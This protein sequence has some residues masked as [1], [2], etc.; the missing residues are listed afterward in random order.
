MRP[1]DG[2]GKNDPVT[3]SG[4]TAADMP[5]LGG[6][7]AVVT[8]ANSGLGLHTT[9]ELARHG[10][11]CVELTTSFRAR[12][13]IQRAVNAGFEPRMQG[14]PVALQARYVP[15]SP[16]RPD[17]PEQPAVSRDVSKGHSENCTTARR[18][19]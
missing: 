17:A 5:D 2:R 12:P 4:W 10:A 16:A 15:L 9:L 19:R 8:G 1:F 11:R 7:R 18:D 14:D 3:S 13:G 6:V